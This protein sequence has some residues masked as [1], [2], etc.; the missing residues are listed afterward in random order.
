MNRMIEPAAERHQA[1]VIGAGQSGLAAAYHLQQRGID[2][3][4]LEAS[5]RVGDGW[6]ARYDSLRLYSPAR[7]DSLPGLRVPLPKRAYPTG[8]QMGDY[9]EAYVAHHKLPVRTGTVVDGLEAAD[10][11]Y[12][13]TAGERR[14]HAEQVVLAGGF[15]R[16]PKVPEFAADLDPAIRQFHSS[17]YHQPSQ[18]ADGPVL[19]V[20]LSHSGAD[21]AL[22]SVKHGHPTTISGRSHG[23]LPFSV[24]S[25]SAS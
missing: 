19:V 4:V 23:Q 8:R 21:L 13:I 15:F 22:E 25:R 2:F 16:R 18:L 5:N 10:D 11:G 17:E 12:L 1:V 24:D 3:V 9:L 6:R 20:G 7:Y 14:F